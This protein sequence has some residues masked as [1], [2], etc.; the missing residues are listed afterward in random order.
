[1]AITATT[2]VLAAYLVVVLLDALV[3]FRAYRCAVNAC[4]GGYG[5]VL[6]RS[7]RERRRCAH[8]VFHSP[9]LW[10]VISVLMGAVAYRVVR[11]TGV[12]A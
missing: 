5:R 3:G 6:G 9:L 4:T 11:D 1:M 7:P 10:A 8:R 12:Q 2:L